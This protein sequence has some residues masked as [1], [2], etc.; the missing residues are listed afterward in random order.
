MV[1]PGQTIAAGDVVVMLEAMKM[2]TE[3]QASSA[4]TVV[5][6]NVKEGDSVK[7]GDALIS[8]S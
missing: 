3:V 4:G 5:E 1:S 6:I 7:V 2:E 8:L